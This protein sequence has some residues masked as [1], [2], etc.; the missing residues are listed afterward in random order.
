LRRG[1]K[2]LSFRIVMVAGVLSPFVA[3][4]ARADGPTLDYLF[5]AGGQRGKTVEL[6]AGGK[7]PNWPIKA[8]TDSPA[9]HVTA[10]K[11]M[12]ALSVQIDTGALIGPH[13]IR[14]YSE[15]GASALRCLP[16]TLSAHTAI[17]AKSSVANSSP[18]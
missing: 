4:V 17:V 12:G 7:F 3:T 2:A 16:F 13:L 1:S 14:S 9:I 8:W 5:P 6:T 11:T 15:D 10:G 18:V